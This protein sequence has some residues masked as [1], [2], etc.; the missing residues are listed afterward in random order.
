MISPGT[1]PLNTI[2]K[3]FRVD[4]QS[5]IGIVLSLKNDVSD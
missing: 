1:L 3:K 2:E 5:R 4:G